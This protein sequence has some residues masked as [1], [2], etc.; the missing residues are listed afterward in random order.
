MELVVLGSGTANPHPARSSAGFWLETSGGTVMLDFSASALHRI[1]QEQLDWANLD[2]VWISHF[3][4]DHCCGL[5]AYLFATRHAPETRDRKKPLTVYGARG[6]TKL[7][8]LFD[9]AAGGKLFKQPF[10]VNIV[11]IEQLEAF[12]ILPRVRAVALSTPHTENSHA[13]R[14][15]DTSGSLAYTSDTGF[16]KEIA[17][18]SK[19]T[20]LMITESSFFK[21]KKVDIHLELAEAMYL[22]RKARPKRAMLTHFYSEWDEVDFKTE[23]SKFDPVCEVLEAVDGLRIDV[24]KQVTDDKE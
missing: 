1:A 4:L 13:F 20:D 3:H 8:E 5:P 19:N 14:I 21:D 9:E 2:A 17:A 18:F 22:I 10:P 11:E 12:E 7:L 6:I 15:E 23:I 24:S 16:G